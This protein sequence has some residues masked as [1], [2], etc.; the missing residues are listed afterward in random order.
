MADAHIFK[1]ET[2]KSLPRF[3]ADFD[4]AARESGFVIHNED[5]MSM[6]DTFVR[7]GV[8]V[9]PGF[10]LHL[11]QV[12]K[13]PKAARAMQTDP[14]R[15]PLIPKFVVAFTRD[16]RTCV[17]MLRLS[18]GLAAELVGD[19]GFPESLEQSY[20]EIADVIR[21]ACLPLAVSLA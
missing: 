4:A 19:G 9:Q 21:Q 5:R 14:E 16:G 3:L 11:I 13:P 15:A 2:E 20:E 12:C 17:R 1:T 18:G 7:H 10:D 6:A 8:A